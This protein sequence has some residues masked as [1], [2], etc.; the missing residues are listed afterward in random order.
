MRNKKFIA[1]ML[2]TVMAVSTALTGCGNSGKSTGDGE[3]SSS[4][5]Y[6]EL[7]SSESS[8]LNYLVT[9]TIVEQ[10][11]GANCIDTLV[12]YDSDGQLKEGLA[13]EWSYDEATLTWTF[14]LREA[15]WVDN[16]GKEV[17]DVTAQDFVDALKYQLTPEYESANV[18]NLF[19]VIAN[20]EEYYNG[21]VY[22]G[23]ADED[24]TTWKEI[25][26]SEQSR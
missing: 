10:V 14:K 13:T 19:G 25:D 23:G 24:G 26:F 21:Q 6:R 11:A 15:K 8:T 16:T 9:S 20:A 5:V 1:M 18:Q 3:S 17:A 4:A 12:E 2:C 22:K 7:Y